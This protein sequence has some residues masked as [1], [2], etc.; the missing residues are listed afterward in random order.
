MSLLRRLW[1]H[2]VRHVLQNLAMAVPP[3]RALARLAHRTG[4]M[5]DPEEVRRRARRVTEAMEA[6]GLLVAGARL[7]EVGPGHTLGVGVALLLAGASELL[8]VDTHPYASPSA[9][10]PYLPLGGEEAVRGALGRLRCRLAGR[11]GR[12]PLEDASADVVYSFSV[13]EHVR[14]VDALLEEAWR[15][16]RPGGLAIHSIDLRDHF[17]LDPG[18]D[19]LRFLRYPD[20]QWDLMTSRRSNWCNRLRSPELRERFARRFELRRF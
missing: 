19:W 5:N 17:Q 8:A 18:E 13:L 2:P 1:D 20:R 9:P 16:L 15:V 3:V 14:S 7:V 12:W 4:A 11:E 10:G 6:E